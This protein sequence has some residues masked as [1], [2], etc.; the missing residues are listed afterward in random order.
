MKSKSALYFDLAFLIGIVYLGLC[1]YYNDNVFTHLYW[2]RLG[3]LILMGICAILDIGFFINKVFI[4]RV[5]PT[6]IH[7]IRT[8]ERIV[9][10][11]LLVLCGFV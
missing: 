9:Y 4:K 11:I 2:T 3:I 8:I 7:Y 10:I 6:I 5:K 1:F